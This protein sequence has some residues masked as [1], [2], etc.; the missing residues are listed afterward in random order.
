M[1]DE[2]L[3]LLAWAFSAF[4]FFMAGQT[5]ATERCPRLEDTNFYTFLENYNGQ[6]TRD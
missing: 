2:L 1:N 3:A 5:Y 6:H 4:C